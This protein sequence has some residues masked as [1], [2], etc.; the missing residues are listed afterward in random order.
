MRAAARGRRVSLRTIRGGLAIIG[1]AIMCSARVGAT[2]FIPDRDEQILER[3]PTR[4]NGTLLDLRALRVRLAQQPSNLSLATQLARGYIEVGRAELDPRYF[5]YAQ[6]ALKP[7]WD[8]SSPPPEVLVLRAILKQHGH[9]FTSALNDLEALLRQDPR[10]AQAW[11]T[12]A[13]VLQVQGDHRQAL[14]HCAALIYLPRSY[15]LGMV[16]LGK[17]LSLSGHADKAYDLLHKL[18]VSEPDAPERERL[19]A[20]TVFAET[21]ARLGRSKQAELYFQQA[22]SLGLRDSYLLMAFAD[23]LLDEDHAARVTRLL[24]HE[25]R[26]DGLLL[27][28]AI[29]EKELGSANNEYVASLKGRFAASRLRGDKVHLGDEARFTLYLLDDPQTALKLALDNWKAQREPRDARIVLE[30]ALAAR[31]PAAA[32]PVLEMLDQSSLEDVRL[33]AL[34]ARLKPVRQ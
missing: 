20:L 30:A 21:A 34:A 29:A 4:L 19:W 13:V 9:D 24:K 17:S 10:N 12:R 23:F 26:V 33:A 25:T 28:L 7:W 31:D 22:L 6:G 5:G 16:C 15:F 18:L 8:L 32:K 2:P 27:R 3:I 14:A 1:L 11:L